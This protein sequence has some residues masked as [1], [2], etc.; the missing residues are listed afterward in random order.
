MS[1]TALVAAVVLAVLA[2]ACEDVID[3][4]VD[5]AETDTVEDGADAEGDDVGTGPIRVSREDFGDDWPLTVDEGVLACV[6]AFAVVF[7]AGG[8]TYAV[9][10]QAAT[11][12]YADIDP[13]WAD[14]PDGLAPKKNIGPLIDRGLELCE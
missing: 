4:G 2:V 7:T 11:Q 8:E 9:N 3:V 6:P 12:G 1:R 14:D 10:G 5:S 13:I